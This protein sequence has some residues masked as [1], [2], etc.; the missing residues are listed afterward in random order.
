MVERSLSMREV[1]GS[2]PGASN[3]FLKPLRNKI[4]GIV[5]KI[6]T[7]FIYRGPKIFLPICTSSNM[8]FLKQFV[9]ELINLFKQI[10]SIKDIYVSICNTFDPSKRISVQIMIIFNTAYFLFVF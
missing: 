5:S 8:H 10:L 4:L 7:I 2:I 6:N 9:S 1:P 3:K